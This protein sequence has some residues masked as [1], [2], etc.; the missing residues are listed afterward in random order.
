MTAAILAVLLLSSP[1]H[2]PISAPVPFAGSA[3]TAQSWSC[4]PRRTCKQISTCDEAVWYLRN[5][6]WGQ[7][8]DGDSDGTPCESLCGN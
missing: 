7:K 8:L 6:N 5:C 2:P 4:T 1:V 3:F